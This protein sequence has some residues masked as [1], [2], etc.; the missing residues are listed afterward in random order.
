MQEVLPLPALGTGSPGA[1]RSKPGS[2]ALFG[3]WI[4]EVLPS[5]ALGAQEVLPLADCSQWGGGFVY[6]L[7]GE[8]PPGALGV[9]GPK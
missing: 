1:N 6:T 5:L 4:Q 2:S 3:H 9:M 8:G 7:E